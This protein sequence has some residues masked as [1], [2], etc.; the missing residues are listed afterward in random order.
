MTLT[1]ERVWSEFNAPLEKY[2]RRRVEDADTAADLLQDVYV[3]IHHHLDDLREEDRLHAWIFG[4]ARNAIT[5][6]YRTRRPVDGIDDDLPDMSE[7]DL[8]NETFDVEKRIARSLLRMINDLPEE[9][10][11]ALILTELDGL[12]Q[13][14]LAERLGISLS[15]AKSRVQRGR[16]LLRE[17][18]LLCCHFHFDRLG[19]VLD[20]QP[21]CGCCI[22]NSADGAA[23]C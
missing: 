1:L 17:M 14:E 7:D 4:I 15:G 3:K 22:L 13:K 8:E 23:T 12:S 11:E 6:H 20:Y 18:L 9:Y 2:I 16:K 5:D 19:A 21:R 10:R